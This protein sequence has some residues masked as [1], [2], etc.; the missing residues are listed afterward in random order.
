MRLKLAKRLKPQNYGCN[1]DGSLYQ[2]RSWISNLVAP[3]LLRVNRLQAPSQ[4]VRQLC[5]AKEARG[6]AGVL[7][8]RVTAGPP[9]GCRPRDRRAPHTSPTQPGTRLVLRD[10]LRPFGLCQRPD[11]ISSLCASAGVAWRTPNTLKCVSSFISRPP[12]CLSSPTKQ[13]ISPS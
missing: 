6:K 8:E 9:A 4:W 11:F 5:V 10:A 7:R 3:G 2:L 12:N 13:T 1:S